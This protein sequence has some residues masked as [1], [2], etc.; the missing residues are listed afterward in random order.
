M[1]NAHSIRKDVEGSGRDLFWIIIPKFTFRNLEK[2]QKF[3]RY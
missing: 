1:I 2:P 3:Q